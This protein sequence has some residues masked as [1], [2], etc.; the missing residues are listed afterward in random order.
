MDEHK[1][2]KMTPQ[3]EENLLRRLKNRRTIGFALI[4]LGL[5]GAISSLTS[6]LPPLGVGFLLSLLGFGMVALSIDNK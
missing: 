2:N 5:V 4:L 3:E 6:V 1:D